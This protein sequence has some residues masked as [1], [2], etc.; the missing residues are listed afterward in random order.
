MFSFGG[1]SAGGRTYSSCIATAVRL[2]ATDAVCIQRFGNRT[3]AESESSSL[4]SLI[5]GFADL[6][7]TTCSQLPPAHRTSA[8]VLID[9]V[10]E[11]GFRG[12]GGLMHQ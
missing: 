3:W 5:V 6:T 1:P 9:R 7:T 12:S 10:Q 8:R 4:Y 2:G 11:Q